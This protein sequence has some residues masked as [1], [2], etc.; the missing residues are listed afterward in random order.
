ML[1]PKIKE[2][3]EITRYISSAI[4][5][6]GKLKDEIITTTVPSKMSKPHVPR[7]RKNLAIGTSNRLAEKQILKRQ[8]VNCGSMKNIQLHHE[9]YYNPFEVIQLCTK[10]HGLLHRGFKVNKQ[11]MI[12]S[13]SKL[14]RKNWDELRCIRRL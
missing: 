9:D 13:A 12:L 1:D 5:H 14:C 6:L 11:P 2:L 7:F 10:C 3:N 8:C 4:F